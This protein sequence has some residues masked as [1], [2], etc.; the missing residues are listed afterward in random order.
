MAR[1]NRASR[2][3]ENK[4]VIVDALRRC[5]ATVQN[6]AGGQGVPD[7]VVGL[8]GRNTLLEVKSGSNGLNDE[9]EKWHGRWRGQVAIVRTVRD[10]FVLVGIEVNN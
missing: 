8:Y 10:A 1:T 6:L 2:P 7:L 5:G 9:Q 4:A 3:D